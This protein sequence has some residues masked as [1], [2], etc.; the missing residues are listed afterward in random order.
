MHQT[1]HVVIGVDP[2]KQSATIEV[3][4]DHER[5][6]GSGRFTTDPAGYT[7]MLKYAKAWP[8]RTWAVEGANGVGRPLAQRLLESGEHVVDGSREPVPEPPLRLA[9]LLQRCVRMDR[10][11]PANGAVADDLLDDVRCDSLGHT[12]GDRGAPQGVRADMPWDRSGLRDPRDHAVGVTSR[13]V[14]TSRTR[15]RSGSMVTSGPNVSRA[16][17]TAD[18]P[19]PPSG[20]WPGRQEA[21]E[22]SP[23]APV[24]RTTRRGGMSDEGRG[25]RS[26][27]GSDRLTR[28]C[29]RRV[30]HRR[31]APGHSRGPRPLR[32][33]SPLSTTRGHAT[34]QTPLLLSRP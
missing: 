16:L 8:Q 23:I 4:D 20:R 12:S 14:P 17:P 34:R 33:T 19:R 30:R 10:H 26:D 28:R 11:G 1:E 21:S 3:V 24:G 2:H 7:A 27:R 32:N 5:K 13:S 9:L 15:S 22:A 18:T 29:G 25:V 31:P 6:L